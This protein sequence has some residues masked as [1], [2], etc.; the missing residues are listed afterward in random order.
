MTW[1]P[2]RQAGSGACTPH[3]TA[4]ANEQPALSSMCMHTIAAA[5]GYSR[6]GNK[7]GLAVPQR[8]GLV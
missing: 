7:T 8:T 3:Q 4:A 5:G 1:L 6:A 2:C